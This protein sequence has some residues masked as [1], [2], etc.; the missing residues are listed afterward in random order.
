[1]AYTLTEINDGQPFKDSLLYFLQIQSVHGIKAHVL[2][3]NVA[4]ILGYIDTDNQ[5]HVPGWS[6]KT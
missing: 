1:M 2:L 5:R 3:K 4:H 6:V